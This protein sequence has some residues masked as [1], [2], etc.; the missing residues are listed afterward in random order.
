MEITTVYLSNLVDF[1]ISVLVMKNPSKIVE[2]E[3]DQDM[4]G[5]RLERI[6]C[7]Y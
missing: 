6:Y 7:K 3:T 1:H 4:Y 2:N 5:R